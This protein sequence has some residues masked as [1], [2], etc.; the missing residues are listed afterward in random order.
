[1]TDHADVEVVDLASAAEEMRKDYRSTADKIERLIAAHSIHTDLTSALDMIEAIA[2][3]AD[4]LEQLPW[5]VHAVPA[6][7]YSAVILYVRATK[8]NS[9]H[10]STLDLRTKF[11]ADQLSFHDNLCKLRDDAV[12]HFG[13]GDLGGGK[14]W[15]EE[16]AILPLDRVDDSKILLASKR[17]GFAPQFV[18]KLRVHVHRAMILAQQEIESR[19]AKVVDALD[20][21]LGDDGFMDL[22][23]RHKGR[24]SEVLDG[25]PE[26]NV[27]FEGDRV[28]IK[29]AHFWD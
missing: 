7:T 5:V 8:S 16:R 15:H 9:K 18:A 26:L 14:A 20:L 10:R 25:H 1:M 13:P 27:I 2:P 3:A 17:V 4:T 22:M 24:F 19:E 21:M 23:K 6:L 11:N 29:S 28:G 12:A